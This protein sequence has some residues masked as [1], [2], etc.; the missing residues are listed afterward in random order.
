MTEN[1][2]KWPLKDILIIEQ[3]NL[4]RKLTQNWNFY[5]CSESWITHIRNRDL[6]THRLPITRSNEALLIHL[7][8]KMIIL[9]IQSV[10]L[11]NPYRQSF[12]EWLR[13][14]FGNF[15]QKNF[16]LYCD[17]T[18]DDNWKGSR[19]IN[20][21]RVGAPRHDITENLLSYLINIFESKADWIEKS[22]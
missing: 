15:F 20:R 11:F 13:G 6:N 4:H 9:L 17:F 1:D 8:I 5:R 10:G 18:T 22:G 3:M 12:G 21:W 7:V 14:F 2:T 16:L 19:G